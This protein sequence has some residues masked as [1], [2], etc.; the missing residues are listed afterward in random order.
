MLRAVV[1]GNGFYRRKLGAIDI[2]GANQSLESLPFTTKDELSADQEQHALYGSNLTFPLSEYCRFHQ[3]SGTRG[4]PLRCLDTAADWQWWMHCWAII[5]RAAGVTPTDR[6]VFPFSFGP[7]IGFW[8]AFEGAVRLGNLCLPA[9][10]MTT[11]ARLRYLLENDVTFVCCTP[12]YALHMAEVAAQ[13]NIG[14]SASAVRGLIVAGE[15]GGSIPATRERIERAWGARVFDHSGMT[16]MG[17]YGF[18]CVES[19]GGMHVCETEFIAEVID[20]VTARP[21]DEG[22][23][24]E[25]VLTNLG[26][27]GKPLIRYRTGD[28]VRMT[29]GRCACGRWFAR[30]EGG[31]LGRI[32]DMIII[33]G[34]N[35][36]PAAIE[37]ILRRFDD[38]AEYCVEIREA[39]GLSELCIQIEPAA[40]SDAQSLQSL[41]AQA[42][43]DSLN[44][45]PQIRIVEIGS[46]PRYE[47]KAARWIRRV[48]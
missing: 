16:E 7:F 39:A 11:R 9:G 34:N 41:V 25:L 36:F 19:P 18:E 27:V 46:L 20:P 1:A 42:V 21:V 5:F 38:I 26:R 48:D 3:T 24:G 35:V 40:G 37:G 2:A 47:M 33:R 12:T 22:T 10:G 14:L 43:R 30:L 32:D 44:L 28:M 29:H 13:E 4:E 8:A 6:L 23:T 31:I 45:R 17:P 15:P